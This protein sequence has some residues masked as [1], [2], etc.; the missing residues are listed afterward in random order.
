MGVKDGGCSDGKGGGERGGGISMSSCTAVRE[1]G[2]F[3]A[4]KR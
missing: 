1:D 2:I 4:F 3:S